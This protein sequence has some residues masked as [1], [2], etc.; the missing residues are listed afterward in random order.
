MEHLKCKPAVS[1]FRRAVRARQR[2]IIALSTWHPTFYKQT[3]INFPQILISPFP[4]NKI[5]ILCLYEIDRKSRKYRATKAIV[6]IIT[7]F[8]IHIVGPVVCLARNGI[9]TRLSV[10]A[11]SRFD[12]DNLP[13]SVHPFIGAVTANIFIYKLKQTTKTKQQQQKN[14]E[15]NAF[16]RFRLLNWNV[17]PRY[18][19]D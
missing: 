6:I 18:R 17:V 1:P 11:P 10:Y 4:L 14:E 5:Y 9:D 8:F 2:Y 16:C 12:L 15:K 3:W 19:R 7:S 13:H